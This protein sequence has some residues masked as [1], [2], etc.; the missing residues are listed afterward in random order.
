VEIVDVSDEALM[1]AYRDGDIRAFN[2]LFERHRDNLYRYLVRQSGNQSVAEELCQ[3]AWAALIKNRRT[4][5]VEAKFKTYLFHIAHNKLIDYYRANSKMDAVSYDETE[6]DIQ[7]IPQHDNPDMQADTEQKINKLL[8]LLGK[9]PAAQ[10]DVF[11]MHEETGMSL[12]E[13]AEVMGVS[14][15]TVKSRLRYALQRLRRGMGR[16]Q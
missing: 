12:P 14:R 5:R 6:H 9:M 8:E 13:I 10:R 3:D 4:Y 11:L 2:R 1:E 15:D 7:S 16:M